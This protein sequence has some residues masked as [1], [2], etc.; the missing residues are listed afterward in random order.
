M[1][2]GTDWVQ[3]NWRVTVE[4]K[5]SVNKL[6]GIFPSLITT[7]HES[8][9]TSPK[10]VAEPVTDSTEVDKT[11]MDSVSVEQG[12]LLRAAEPDQFVLKVNTQRQR[13]TLSSS[14]T[15]CWV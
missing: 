9:A 8:G 1:R 2:S 6:A 12:Q 14:H 13:D 4:G 7:V 3:A 5:S 15:H 10:D 11:S